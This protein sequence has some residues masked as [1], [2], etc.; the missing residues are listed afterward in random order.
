ML[1]SGETGHRKLLLRSFRSGATHA[2]AW[3]LS[4]V[5]C[6]W[7]VTGVCAS[8]AGGVRRVDPETRLKRN[9]MRPKASRLH[10]SAERSRRRWYRRG[11]AQAVFFLISGADTRRKAFN[12]ASILLGIIGGSRTMRP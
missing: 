1:R 9:W 7:K 12:V 2:I 6:F 8:K 4:F 11:A 5:N 3:M 10:S